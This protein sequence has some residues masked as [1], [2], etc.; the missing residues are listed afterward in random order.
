MES[1]VR[2]SYMKV[3]M[4]NKTLFH[5]LILQIWLKQN[6]MLGSYDGL[7]EQ[8]VTFIFCHL[9]RRGLLYSRLTPLNAFKIAINFI[10]TEI[11]NGYTRGLGSLDQVGESNGNNLC[12]FLTLEGKD[13]KRIAYNSLWRVSEN[14]VIELIF[15]ARTCLS[16]LEVDHHSFSPHPTIPYPI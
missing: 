9:F 8:A 7:S 11:E 12:I 3:S 14:A 2:N 6:H 16:Y 4:M 13:S 5:P 15:R 1:H 10:A